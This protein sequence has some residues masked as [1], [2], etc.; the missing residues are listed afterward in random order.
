MSDFKE[1]AMEN[2]SVAES[3][4]RLI[5]EALDSG[6]AASIGEAEEM[7][8][9]FR[10]GFEI[11]EEDAQ[12]AM[13]QAALLTGVALARRVFLGGVRVS[14][15]E[16]VPI[17]LGLPVGN[18]L[19]EAVVNLGGKLASPGGDP[20]VTFGSRPRKRS[21]RFHIRTV[22][23]GWRGGIVP[24]YS[25]ITMAGAG[26]V[27]LAP[28]LAGALAVNECFGFV[29]SKGVIFGKRAVGLSLWKPAASEDWTEPASDGP[30]VTYLPDRLWLIGLG[31]LG[32]AFLW[33]LGLLDYS[34]PSALSVVLQDVDVITPASVSTSVL[35][36]ASLIG[37]K[38]TRALADWCGARGFDASIIERRF[39]A[40]FCRQPHEP[41]IA[42]CGV[43][44]ALARQD[45][46]QAGFDFI[47]EAG[48]GRGHLNYRSM[49]LHTLPGPRSAASIWKS[50][51]DVNGVES[52][53]AYE[54]LL[55][56]GGLDRCGITLLAGKA[57]GAPFVGAVAACFAIA[58]ILRLLHGG[59][60][61]ELIELDLQA[62]EHRVRCLILLISRP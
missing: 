36:D 7:F 8:K 9:G 44:N 6:A 52:R 1:I 24:A 16:G 20:L 2:Y 53:P 57:V 38:K 14:C 50:G 61:H 37:R 59:T 60:V 46:D 32:Q 25:E 55:K 33:A 15:P 13:Q 18:T 30:P 34:D 11:S 28:M 27:P 42:L 56:D 35:T 29:R 19:G 45:L 39:K 51:E 58:E 17:K 40:D 41:S 3:L 47:V 26:A 54:K 23:E 62:V 49:R 5:K 10:V 4:H 43:D 22:F 12:D 21:D 31:H 48:L